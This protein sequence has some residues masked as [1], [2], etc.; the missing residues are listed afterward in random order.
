MPEALETTLEMQ[1]PQPPEMLGEFVHDYP[2]NVMPALD[3]PA[4]VSKTFLTPDTKLYNLDHEHLAIAME[5]NEIGFLWISG[6]NTKKGKVVIGTCEMVNFTGDKW[7]QIRKKQQLME[8]Y[9]LDLPD[10]I[11]S[12]DAD[13]CRECSDTEF[14]ALVE[15]ELYHI[16]HEIDNDGE[17][18]FNRTTD[19]PLLAI[20]G[21]DVEEFTGVVRRYGPAHGVSEIVEV[22][23]QVPEVAVEDV[24]GACN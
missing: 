19:N 24:R 1:R 16:V 6:E 11:I 18:K 10:F 2:V 8:W 3:M 17:P 7:A 13:Y 12:L 15:H 23:N 22:A 4:W 9:G 14:C 5:T 21:H 20:Q